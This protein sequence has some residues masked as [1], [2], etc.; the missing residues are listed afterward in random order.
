MRYSGVF[1][2][3]PGVLVDV[4]GIQPLK[5]GTPGV[6]QV[7]LLRLRQRRRPGPKRRAKAISRRRGSCANSGVPQQVLPPVGPGGG[8]GGRRAG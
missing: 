6:F 5:V 7:L 3:V 2:D 8:A 1:P 4:L